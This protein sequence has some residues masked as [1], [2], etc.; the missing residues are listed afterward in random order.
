MSETYVKGLAELQRF[1]DTL[2]AKI[3]KNIMRGAL[4]AGVN[5]LKPAVAA[6]IHS[7]SGDLLASLRI[8]VRVK[9]GQVVAAVKTDHWTAKWV[10]YGTRQHWISVQDSARPGRN[11]RRGWR[12]FSIGTLNRMA[13]RGSLIIGRNF[14]GQ[15]VTHPG[16]APHPYMR[17]A[18]DTHA[19]AAVVAVGNYVKQRLATKH[20]LDTSEVIVEEGEA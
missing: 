9:G 19:Q 13:D 10:E 7:V 2:P 4:R 15:S 16:A 14:V 18:L 1:L 5:V 17:R 12:A 3:E 6:N 8:S 20:G 11:T